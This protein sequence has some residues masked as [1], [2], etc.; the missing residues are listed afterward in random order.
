MSAAMRHQMT[1]ISEATRRGVR[2]AARAAESAETRFESGLQK[3]WHHF[4]ERVW[5]KIAGIQ[6]SIRL[7]RD[8]QSAM[9][10]LRAERRRI[11]DRKAEQR[12][13]N[14]SKALWMLGLEEELAAIRRV[15]ASL[16]QAVFSGEFSDSS[17]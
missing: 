6:G 16:H 4:E 17:Q 13:A 3:L 7:R 11:R 8:L 9:D 15:K 5:R 1:F 14:L 2:E 12:L 10:K